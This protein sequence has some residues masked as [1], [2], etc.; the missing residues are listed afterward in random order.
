MMTGCPLL[1]SFTIEI[2]NN[3][4]NIAV[5]S[6]RLIDFEA[7]EDVSDNL[8]AED[9]ASGTTKRV[10]V[11]M[12]NVGTGD[13]LKV[14]VESENPQQPIS[15]AV[16]RKVNGGFAASKTVTV[17][18]DGSPTQSVSIDVETEEQES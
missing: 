8:L 4:N 1:N 7:Q 16:T 9:V 3:G 2:I 14:R 6:I 18:V 13:A 15:F 12:D 5:T 10:L 17:T 11:L